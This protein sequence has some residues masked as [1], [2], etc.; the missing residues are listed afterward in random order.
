MNSENLHK[1]R[2]EKRG[3]GAAAFKIPN[4]KGI[5]SQEIISY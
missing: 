1:G 2:K 5:E 4:L 3:E